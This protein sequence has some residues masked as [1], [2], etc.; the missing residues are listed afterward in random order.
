MEELPAAVNEI[1]VTKT[2]GELVEAGVIT[3]SQGNKIVL[4]DYTAS[5]TI[6]ELITLIA[7]NGGIVPNP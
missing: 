2:I 3:D 4:D 7:T 6:N 1:F 5:L